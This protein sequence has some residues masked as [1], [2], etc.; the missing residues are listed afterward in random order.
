[1]KAISP[2]MSMAL[3][4]LLVI[5]AAGGYNVY[6]GGIQNKLI[7]QYEDN[8]IYPTN[9]PQTMGIICY[10]GYGFI[11]LLNTSV[12][13]IV[14]TVNY[15]VKVGDTTLTGQRTVNFTDYGRIYF[16]IP[17]DVGGKIKF[18]LY[19][20]DWNI[21]DVCTVRED[22]TLKLHLPF[23]ET[24]GTTTKDESKY[25][26]DGTLS[27]Y[28]A[29]GTLTAVN[30]GT[31]TDATWVDGYF[32]KAL[33]FDGAADYVTVPSDAGILE[34]V[35]N[36]M[37]LSLWIK[38]DTAS[39]TDWKRIVEKDLNGFSLTFDNSPKLQWQLGNS[40][41]YQSFDS[42]SNVIPD[43]WTHIAVNYNSS[44]GVA[45]MYINGTY[46]TQMTYTL[47]NVNTS[48]NDLYI[49]SRLG[50]CN[51]YTGLIDEVKL[52]GRVLNDTEISS[53][54][55][56]ENLTNGLNFYFKMDEGR[57]S[58]TEDSHVW[59]KE[60]GRTS[61]HFSENHEK[62]I[63]S[64]PGMN[65]TNF[66]FSLWVKLHDTSIGDII[67]TQMGDIPSGTFH[68]RGLYFSNTTSKFHL[69]SRDAAA[70]WKQ[71]S[72]EVVEEDTWYHLVG[73]QSEEILKIYLNGTLSNTYDMVT[74]LP[75]FYGLFSLGAYTNSTDAPL[76]GELDDVRIYD[77]NISAEEV[78]M[79]YLG[80]DVSEGLVGR[81]EFDEQSGALIKDSHMW[82]TG[83]SGTAINFDG[84]DDFVN[85][86]SSSSLKAYTPTISA[87]FKTTSSQENLM[88]Y[89]WR[90]Y[91]LAARLNWNST[92]LGKLAFAFNDAAA[93]YYYVVS[94]Q[95]YTD[96]SWHHM[97]ASFNGTSLNL[98]LD[99][100]EVSS[101]TT[102]ANMYYGSGG[103]SV[104][105][106]GDYNGSFFAGSVDDVRLYDKALS[107]DAIYA[108]YD[109]YQ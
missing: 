103:A 11:D 78:G 56:N 29:D 40:T 8:V 34:G 72:T 82:T 12:G 74:F 44:D 18:E 53:V 75:S 65:S 32:G 87:W 91:G 100:L 95:T 89:R 2:V 101:S 50:C 81:W 64:M 69:F 90:L 77:R 85:I 106:D 4:L 55:Q 30:D 21:N 45:K 37:T 6:V 79:L 43:V 96:G 76:N 33:Y 80:Q 68:C 10:P 17:S 26:N 60:S 24:S 28:V 63:V 31:I 58:T 73:V 104:G 5:G 54:Y 47:N 27:G 19:T 7:N 9:P 93:N 35:V 48:T 23:D 15:F 42:I 3:L 51:Y 62:T 41:H 38:A 46:E 97:A 86:G 70:S 83:I 57:G 61:L 1:M 92:Y 49:G 25:D 88:I 99:G 102:N 105:R 71:T 52:Y 59:N 16:G 109:T 67:I 36:Q 39:M 98:Y 107:S 14:G 20:P 94:P 108:L 13:G 84:V 66:S 22:T